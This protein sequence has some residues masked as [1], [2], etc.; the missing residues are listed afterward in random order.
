MRADRR[1]YQAKLKASGRTP[2][3]RAH[4]SAAFDDL[5][6]ADGVPQRALRCQQCRSELAILVTQ[7]D[8]RQ[9]L[10]VGGAGRVVVALDP[11]GRDTLRIE[12]PGCEVF[13]TVASRRTLLPRAATSQQ[14]AIVGRV[15]VGR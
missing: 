2:W 13:R 12:C 4:A 9:F 1:R 11:N 15:A 14:T 7:R 10:L 8:G 3:Y 5:A 6:R